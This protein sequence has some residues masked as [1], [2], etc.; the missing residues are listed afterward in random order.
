VRPKKFEVAVYNKDV[1]RLLKEGRKH[2]DLKDDW[3]DMHYIDVKADDV[4]AARTK[5]SQKYPESQGFVIDNVVR[6][7]E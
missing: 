3:A 1:R 5:I 6:M 2:R 4:A 7:D